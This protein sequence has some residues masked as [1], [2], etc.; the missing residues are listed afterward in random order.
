MRQLRNCLF[1]GVRSRKNY[2]VT[3]GVLLL[4]MAP[5][6]LLRAPAI[7]AAAPAAGT[8]L[9]LDQ[10]LNF[11]GGSGTTNTVDVSAYQSVRVYVDGGGS[12]ANCLLHIK[13]VPPGIGFLML[14]SLW[15]PNTA[16]GAFTRVYEVPGKN[17]AMTFWH[18][19]DTSTG[20]YRIVIYGRP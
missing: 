15:W 2:V 3:A 1:A 19:A 20:S 18:S 16:C 13:T 7:Q 6:A 14:D 8:V 4:V 9:V 10:T 12:T 5:V 11:T 17:L